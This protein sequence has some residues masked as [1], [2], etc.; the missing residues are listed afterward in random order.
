MRGVTS[1]RVEQVA[2]VVATVV[3]RTV[4]ALMGGD[5]PGSE[6]WHIVGVNSQILHVPLHFYGGH[7]ST[8][9]VVPNLNK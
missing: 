8:I 1:L 4:V 2:I 7:R 5:T 9:H 6:E 3:A